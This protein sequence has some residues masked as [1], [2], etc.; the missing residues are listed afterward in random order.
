MA[1][2]A[3]FNYSRTGPPAEAGRNENHR[4]LG[5]YDAPFFVVPRRCARRLPAACAAGLG[6]GRR[7]RAALPSR[8]ARSD[9]RGRCVRCDRCG[10]RGGHRRPGGRGRAAGAP[11]R[12][13][14]RGARAGRRRPLRRGARHPGAAG[15][16]SRGRG[17][18]GLPLRPRRRGRIAAPPGLGRE[19]RGTAE[20]GDRRLPLH[21]AGAARPPAGAARARA[22]LLP[23]GRR[24]A[25][26]APLRP[27]AGRQPAGAGGRQR[28]PLPARD[29]RA[30]ALELQAGRRARAGQQHR[31]HLGGAHHLHLRP[32]FPSGTPRSSPPPA[33]ASRSGA[34]RST[35]TC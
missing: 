20:G 8:Q 2:S 23:Q 26:P 21:A 7:D 27:G 22:R 30:R 17:Q 16:G 6:R 1:L 25:R 5:S 3:R 15:L 32:A 34:A 19:S 4:I 31:R 33:S 29:R 10:R 28:P 11:H 35:S 24:P 18:R 13:V 9:C 14:G 12:R